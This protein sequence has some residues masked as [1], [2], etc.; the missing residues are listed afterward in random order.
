MVARGESVGFKKRFTD[1]DFFRFAW[2]DITTA[3]DKKIVQHRR[4][5]IGY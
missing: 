4:S 3:L 2:I 1:D 5:V